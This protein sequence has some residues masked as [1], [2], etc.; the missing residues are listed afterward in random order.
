MNPPGSRGLMFREPVRQVGPLK[1]KNEKTFSQ[2]G[3]W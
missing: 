3:R 1:E 2:N